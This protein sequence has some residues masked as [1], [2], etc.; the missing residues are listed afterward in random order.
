MNTSM[1]S[2]RGSAQRREGGRLEDARALHVEH[3]VRHLE[4]VRPAR[5]GGH[6]LAPG[7]AVAEAVVLPPG[8]DVIELADI[9]GEVAEEFSQVL[10]LDRQS[11]LAVEPDEL[12]ELAVSHPVVA[13]LDDHLC[14]ALAVVALV[15]P[16]E[17]G[18]GLDFGDVL[19]PR[20]WGGRRI[21]GPHRPAD[22][23]KEAVEPARQ[24]DPE[25][26]HRLVVRVEEV[27]PPVLVD[28]D[29]RALLERMVDAV[30]AGD[31][32][33]IEDD[34]DLLLAGMGVLTDEASRRD[35][36]RA[37]REVR[38]GAGRRLA[39]D[40]ADEAVRRHRLPEEIAALRPD[41][42]E[43]RSWCDLRVHG[44]LRSR[45]ILN[46]A[47][48]V[49]EAGLSARG[50]GEGPGRGTEGLSRLRREGWALTRSRSRAT[51]PLSFGR[52]WR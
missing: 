24:Q 19:G 43:V 42:L 50:R 31:A 14:L 8:D 12:G 27:V 36:L 48:A 45:L 18:P 37:D 13:F 1:A 4:V 52:G 26:G 41:D 7:L 21:A 17:H 33:A 51:R 44:R 47:P 35:G 28:E 6:A 20:E 15:G 25:E 11:A 49:P 29:R 46:P 39:Q 16:A 30:D 5:V 38:C 22:L 9:G 10:L 23:G 3:A 2:A 40:V 32:A 34:D